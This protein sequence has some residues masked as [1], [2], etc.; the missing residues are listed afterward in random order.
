MES[1][2]KACWRPA[3]NEPAV[4]KAWAMTF[5]SFGANRKAAAAALAK[6]PM[7]PVVWKKW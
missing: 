6:H 3:A 1:E 7:V 2:R 4:A 5:R